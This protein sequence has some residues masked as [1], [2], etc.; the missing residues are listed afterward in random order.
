MSFTGI[1]KWK[2]NYK[3]LG[4]LRFW[5]TVGGVILWIA[6]NVWIRITLHWPDHYGFRCHE[7]GCFFED[8]WY[9]PVLL[10]H[11]H[12]LEIAL[13]MWIWALPA[14]I[15]CIIIWSRYQSRKRARDLSLS[16][17][18]SASE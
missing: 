16:S 5:L 10:K 2:E 8:M 12:P 14:F 11:G 17:L 3:K 9:S 1:P 6:L 7:R 18:N 4:P 15:P 13:F